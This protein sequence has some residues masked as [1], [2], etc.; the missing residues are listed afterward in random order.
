MAK[1][2]TTSNPVSTTIDHSI[3]T[4]I[5][6]DDKSQPTSGAHVSITP[7]DASATTNSAGEVQF[8]LGTAIK[9]NVTASYGNNTVTVPYYVTKD[10]TA[11]LVV[12]PVYVKTIQD[13]QHPQSF[14]SGVLPVLGIGLG[15]IIV[16]YIV[17][18][19]L[20]KRK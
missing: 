18:R 15:I 11:R 3:L 16:V 2:L 1:T 17:W 19:L 14:F 5:V 12:N 20:R 13:Q 6:L 8:H 4:V 7:S 10:G 9:Y